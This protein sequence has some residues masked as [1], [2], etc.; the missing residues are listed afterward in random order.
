VCGKIWIM[1]MP[2]NSSCGSIQ[3]RVSAAPPQLNSPGEPRAPD[4]YYVIEAVNPKG[5]GLDGATRSSVE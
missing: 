3:N 5:R 1:K 2:I 4:E